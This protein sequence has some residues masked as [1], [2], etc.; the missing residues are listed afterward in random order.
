MFNGTERFLIE[1]IRVNNVYHI[2]GM[3][4]TQAEIISPILFLAGLVMFIILNK[5]SKQV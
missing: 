1:L 3:A 2:G 5:Q 4:I